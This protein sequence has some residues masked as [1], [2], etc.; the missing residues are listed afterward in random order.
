MPF[1]FVLVF[2]TGPD[3]VVALDG[4]IVMFTCTVRNASDLHFR[5]NNSAADFYSTEEIEQ[6]GA[7]TLKDAV[8]RRNLTVIASSLYNNT[9]IYC[10]AYHSSNMNV[11][12]DSR[13]AYLTVQGFWTISFNSSCTKVLFC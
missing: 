1:Y 10:K 3:S 7:E 13:K 9:K 2:I 8:L 12:A 4:T 5:V 6:L 11:E